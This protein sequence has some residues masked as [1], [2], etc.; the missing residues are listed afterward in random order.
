MTIIIAFLSPSDL[1]MYLELSNCNSNIFHIDSYQSLYMY[2]NIDDWVEIIRSHINGNMSTDELN[3]Y[4]DTRLT[5]STISEYQS[6][7]ETYQ[8]QNRYLSIFPSS[9]TAYRRNV[10]PDIPDSLYKRM[11]ESLKDKQIILKATGSYVSFDFTC[12]SEP[13]EIFEDIFKETNGEIVASPKMLAEQIA[14]QLTDLAMDNSYLLRRIEM[15]EAQIE[16]FTLRNNNLLQEV[17]NKN[18]TSWY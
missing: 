3:T 16:D 12:F 18:L 7:Y 15:L 14:T 9:K 11:Y 1:K 17:Y 8:N 6:R 2:D 13:I 4:V 10:H 5:E